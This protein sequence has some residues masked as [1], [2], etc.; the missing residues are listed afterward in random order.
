[1]IC[2]LQRPSNWG[3]FGR[4][5][6]KETRSKEISWQTRLVVK[7]TSDDPVQGSRDS[8][9]GSIGETLRRKKGWTLV[10]N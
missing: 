8:R 1:M 10:T 2:A 7:E 3:E 4:V 6:G 5:E 9:E